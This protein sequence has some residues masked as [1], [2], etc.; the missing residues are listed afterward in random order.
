MSQSLMAKRRAEPDN[1]AWL[2]VTEAA[3][4]IDVS[5]KQVLR[6]AKNGSLETNGNTGDER[7]IM[8]A[9]ASARDHNRR[10][11]DRGANRE[12]QAVGRRTGAQVG[13]TRRSQ[14]RGGN[15]L[16]NL[17][18]RQPIV[19]V[20]TFTVHYGGKS[21]IL[22]NTK[23]FSFFAALARRPGIYVNVERLIDAVWN[24]DKRSD[25]AIKTVPS[26]LRRALK[27]AGM[28]NMRI[29]GKT[30][31]GHYALILP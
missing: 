13:E 26:N 8:V 25:S 2:T 31:R 22:R 19:D 20:D 9:L 29:D 7:Q 5:S 30:N 18:S 27:E 15:D 28:S 1:A 21:C 6:W 3:R 24:G 23:E 14:E 4:L 17:G 16:K 10:R 12:D 11:R